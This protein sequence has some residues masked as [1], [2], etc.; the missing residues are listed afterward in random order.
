MTEQD[1]IKQVTKRAVDYNE[2]NIKEFIR[3]TCMLSVKDISALNDHGWT[4]AYTTDKKDG[5][6]VTFSRWKDDK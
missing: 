3:F 1:K 2:N 6:E 5:Y 4:L